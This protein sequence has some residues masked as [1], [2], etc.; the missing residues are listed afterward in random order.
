MHQW[1]HLQPVAAITGGA[2]GIGLALA[3]ELHHRGYQIGLIDINSAALKTA[4]EGVLKHAKCIS[5]VADVSNE[6]E[7]KAAANT[8]FNHFKRIDMLINNAG[9]SGPIEAL[10]NISSTK[11]QTIL[12]VNLMGALHGIKA[13]MPYLSNPNN[14]SYIVNMAS[15]LGLSSCSG[16]SL[17]NASKSALI[18]MSESLHHDL[19]KTKRNIVVSVVCPGLMDTKLLLKDEFQNQ[20]PELFEQLKALSHDLNHSAS[21]IL[22]SVMADEFYILPHK[23]VTKY[24][25]LRAKDITH[26]NKPSANHLERVFEAFGQTSRRKEEQLEEA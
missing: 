21:R 13:F 24:A 10:W 9:V 6:N 7:M 15:M 3:R 8:I 26:H 19:S 4:Q 18:G 5:V 16:L 2:S 23:E 11:A 12:T 22:D 14:K 17:Y 25:R 1:Q 20:D